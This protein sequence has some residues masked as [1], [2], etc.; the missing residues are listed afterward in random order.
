MRKAIALLTYNRYDNFRLTWESIKNQKINGRDVSE[1]YDIYIF[2]D[3]LLSNCSK[4]EQEGFEKINEYL[5][6]QIPS[7]SV[8]CQSDNLGIAL[9]YDF[10]EKFLFLQN[11]YDVVVFFEDDLI[12]SKPYMLAMDM[13][14]EKFHDDHRVGMF[15]AHPADPTIALEKQRERKHEYT[16]MGH[17]W[18]FGI[19]R[20]FWKKRQPFIECY[21]ELLGHIPYQYRPNAVIREWLVR[22]GFNP[23]ATSQDYIKSC[24]TYALGAV[25]LSTFPNYATPIG[26]TGVHSN[27]SLFEKMGLHKTKVF[28][29]DIES[30]SDLTDDLYRKLW[31]RTGHQV[32]CQHVR[33]ISNAK[34]HSFALFEKNLLNNKYKPT[35]PEL[36]ACILE[37]RANFL[38][39]ELEQSTVIAK[40]LEARVHQLSNQLADS[41][42]A[43]NSLDA[44]LN[45]HS[46]RITQPFRLLASAIRSVHCHI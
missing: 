7:T 18:G 30:A 37:A 2:Q 43:R 4:E 26:K 32:D 29:A 39:D 45:S 40:H 24:A 28:D 38:A 19:T 14:I 46:W 12:L 34:T 25:K 22:C 16:N 17:N 21:L 35:S 15:S 36:F 10:A 20:S 11:N 44:I 9:H 6:T 3:G 13:M 31:N 23:A 8:L 1:M 5:K 27:P 41:I 42:H 33:L